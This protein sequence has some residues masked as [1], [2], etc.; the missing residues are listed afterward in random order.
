MRELIL[1]SRSP[2]RRELLKALG[3]SFRV[4]PP[5]VDE[6]FPA[7]LDAAGAAMAL[8]ERKAEAIAGTVSAGI[9]IGADTLVTDGRRVMGKPK[10]PEDAR[11]ILRRLSRVEHEVW[12]G[13]C[14]IDARTGM[15]RADHVCTRVRMRAMSEEEISAYVAGGEAMGKA[16]AYAIQ[17]SGDRFVEHLDGSLS[18]VVGLPLERL[19]WMLAEFDA[20]EE[21]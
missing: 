12:T 15:R 5:P 20:Q 2:R 7:G 16:G 6:S 19:R 10:D 4:M 14:L 17:E 8:A 21:G 3:R 9:V 1:A 11:A 13:L 18:N